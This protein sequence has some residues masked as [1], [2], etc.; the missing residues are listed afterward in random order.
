MITEYWATL[1]MTTTTEEKEK[2]LIPD[3]VVEEK[4]K[5]TDILIEE[6][7]RERVDVEVTKI[8]ER[9]ATSVVEGLPDI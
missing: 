5:I 2:T 3:I 8:V 7:P 4:R 1:N 6:D 9:E